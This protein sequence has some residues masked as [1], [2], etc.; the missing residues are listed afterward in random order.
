MADFVFRVRHMKFGVLYKWVNG[1]F[2]PGA[3]S[4]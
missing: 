3:A 2:G 4:D 1:W